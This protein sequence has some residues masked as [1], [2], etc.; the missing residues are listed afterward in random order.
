MP[1]NIS[2]R[3]SAEPGVDLESPGL[4]SIRAGIE[5]NTVA[6][7]LSLDYVY[8]G[9]PD[10][11]ATLESIAGY[12]AFREHPLTEGVGTAYLHVIPYALPHRD[13]RNHYFVCKD[14]TGTSR[15]VNNSYPYP[16]P[17]KY[18]ETQEMFQTSVPSNPL[19]RIPQRRE[20]EPAMIPDMSLQVAEI[21][22][23]KPRPTSNV[24]AA[25]TSL[26]DW[27]DNTRAA[28]DECGAWFDSRW[29][30]HTMPIPQ[31][32]VTEPPRVEPFFPG[33]AG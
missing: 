28:P 17:T 24:F 7:F 5:S 13:G 11:T 27:M 16:D 29:G 12:N 3:W 18:N 4:R 31:R 10:P 30:G 6:E 15:K 22:G 33:W 25:S 2:F 23:R 32:A 9:F 21:P 14:M 1:F 8:P 20:D 19:P 26:I